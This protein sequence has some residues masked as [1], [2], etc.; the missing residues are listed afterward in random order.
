MTVCLILVTPFISHEY[1]TDTEFIKYFIIQNQ[2]KYNNF[3][4]VLKEFI[5][6]TLYF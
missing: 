6:T 2:D 5:K 1:K 4:D 3:T